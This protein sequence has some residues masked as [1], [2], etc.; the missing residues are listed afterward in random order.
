MRLQDSWITAAN[1]DTGFLQSWFEADPEI[2]ELGLAAGLNWGA[3]SGLVLSITVSAS[4]WATVAWIA[5][6][7]W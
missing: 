3:I 6:R 5:T 4:F 7:I 2:D 1:L